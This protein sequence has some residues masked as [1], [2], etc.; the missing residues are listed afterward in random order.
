[1]EFYTYETLFVFWLA[2]S[3]IPPVVASKRGRRGVEW[4]IIGIL[5]SPVIATIVVVAMKDL[6]K[7]RCEACGVQ[8]PVAAH[9]CPF[10][11]AKDVS[12][13]PPYPPSHPVFP[14]APVQPG[15]S[16]QVHQYCAN[17]GT[18]LAPDARFCS[19]CGRP[20]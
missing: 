1:M 17:C 2:F 14:V 10:C 12:E 8:I 13:T 20:A 15:P 18:K 5:I 4:F 19:S 16:Q 6:S 3:L 7:K 11:K 9:I